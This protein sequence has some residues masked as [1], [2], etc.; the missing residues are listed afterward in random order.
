MNEDTKDLREEGAK[1]LEALLTEP[2][3]EEK[4]E[5]LTSE[6]AAD[7]VEVA[8][9]PTPEEA[10]EIRKKKK[11]RIAQ[12]LTRGILNQKLGAIV[13]DGTPEGRRGKLVLDSDEK[14]LQYQNLGFEFEY[15][16]GAKGLNA[17]SDG[18]IRVGDL[19]LM[20][21]SDDDYSILDEV[22][23]DKV[24]EKLSAG[25]EEYKR[26]VREAGEEEGM[27]DASSTEVVTS[28]G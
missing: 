16:E 20:T 4:T 11:E 19:V 10:L 26:Q 21:V 25:R 12:V 5:E 3:E 27:M 14:I 18:R 28:R 6:Q 1:A 7:V 22:R 9:E 23:S 13:E 2:E 17:T 8:T 15:R 24:K